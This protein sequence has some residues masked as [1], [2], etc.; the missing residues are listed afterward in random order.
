[1][2]RFHAKAA[3]PAAVSL[4]LL[5]GCAGGPV[6][7]PT[8]TAT[9]PS[10]TATPTSTFNDE[11]QQAVAAVTRFYEVLD[12]VATDDE[13]SLN[14]LHEVAAG[15]LVDQRLQTYQ[16]YRVAG[17]RQ[18]GRTKV[19]EV[20]SVTGGAGAFEVTVCVDRSDV[21]LLDPQGKSIISADSPR[22]V[23]HQ[24]GIREVGGSLRAVQ[25]EAISTC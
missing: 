13:V 17:V 5:A 21:D 11:Q 25:D 16:Q 3:I 15:D 9:T 6:A 14:A 7:S 18:T 22:R 10:A 4:L 19:G 1:M 8:P 24:F 20:S 12:Q 23:V 2:T